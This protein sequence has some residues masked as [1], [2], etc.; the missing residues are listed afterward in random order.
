MSY[1]EFLYSSLLTIVIVVLLLLLVAYVYRRINRYIRYKTIC[2][3]RKLEFDNIELKNKLESRLSYQ[4]SYLDGLSSP[5][6]IEG[7]KLVREYDIVYPILNVCNV[8]NIDIE[9][10]DIDMYYYNLFN[11][12]KFKMNYIKKIVLKP[13]HSKDLYLSIRNDLYDGLTDYKLK[14]SVNRVLFSDGTVWK[15]NN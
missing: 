3:Q 4:G 5:L 2:K 11:D 13:L 8:G 6:F 12:F 1:I 15:K 10:I 7:Y 9:C 14:I